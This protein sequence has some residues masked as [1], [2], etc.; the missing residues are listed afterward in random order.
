MAGGGVAPT[1]ASSEKSP[2]AGATAINAA[3]FS[4]LGGGSQQAPQQAAQ[5]PQQQYYRPQQQYYQPQQQSYQP[6]QQAA[7]YNPYRAQPSQTLNIPG[8]QG[9][10]NPFYSAPKPATAQPQNNLMAQ[11]AAYQQKQAAANQAAKA[12]QLEQTKRLQQAYADKQAADK[13]KAE[14]LAQQQYSYYDGGG[15]YSDAAGNRDSS[16]TGSSYAQGG[17]ASLTGKR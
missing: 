17:I 10:S 11:Y 2:S 3:L 14:A 8:F 15:G 1:T 9:M 6:Q 4:Q 7:L 16:W 13:A 12:A 5:Q